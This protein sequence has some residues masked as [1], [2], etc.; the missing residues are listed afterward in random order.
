MACD[1]NASRRPVNRH[2]PLLEPLEC[3]RLMSFVPIISAA[4]LSADSSTYSSGNVDPKLVNPNGLVATPDGRLTVANRGSATLTQYNSA[5]VQ[6][7][8]AASPLVV[9]IA[10]ATPGTA[11]MP[12]AL[13]AHAGNGF[14]LSVNGKSYPSR[15]IAA[16]NDG[17]I[18]GFNPAAGN[19]AVIAVNHASTGD[20]FTG[21]ATLN[22]RLFAA[23]FHNSRIEVFDSS[24]N[25]LTLRS[26]A[27]HDPEVPAGYAPFGVSALRGKI[28]V[29]YARQD[30][31]A[32]APN[33]G[34]AQGIIDTYSAGGQLL[35]RVATGGD[36]NSPWGLAIAPQSWGV[37]KNDLVVAN[38]GDGS[39]SLYT[40]KNV[41]IEQLPSSTSIS[42]I[43]QIDNLWGLSPGVGKSSNTLFFVSAPNTSQDGVLGALTAT[44]PKPVKK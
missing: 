30:S 40:P 5:G 32:A 44:R 9:S 33:S 7:P 41:F 14:P 6:Q 23:D 38:V 39:I 15:F 13:V 21:L 17:A 12:T 25:P 19:S 10:G 31:A 18:A 16:T 26:T 2:A 43:L 28:Y 37:F 27:F 34:P 42:G 36:L 35:K 1:S 24:F 3:R 4:V 22:G 8:S 29:T 11:G 20:V